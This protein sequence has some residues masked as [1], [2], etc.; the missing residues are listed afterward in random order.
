MLKEKVSCFQDSSRHSPYSGSHGDKDKTLKNEQSRRVCPLPDLLMERGFLD[1]IQA[2]QHNRVFPQLKHGGN[3]YGDA[4]GKAW[5]RLV[6]RLKVGGRGKV[7]HS[8]R[9]G[10]CTKL[11]E[12]GVPDAHAYALTGHVRGG[13]GGDVHQGYVHMDKFSLKALK[14]SIDKLGEAYREML[15]ELL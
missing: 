6:K 12:L 7:F 14:A 13:G 10:G 3:G 5:A 11:A 15:K 8:L 4:P 1:Y 2:I 9:H